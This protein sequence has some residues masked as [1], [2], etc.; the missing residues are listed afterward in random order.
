MSLYP[1]FCL[2][3]QSLWPSCI[4][5][6]SACEVHLERHL[7]E[8]VFH[9]HSG[10]LRQVHLISLLLEF[11]IVAGIPY[12]HQIQGDTVSSTDMGSARPACSPSHYT[13]SPDPFHPWLSPD[14]GPSL[15]PVSV[16]CPG[17]SVQSLPLS[18]YL[19]SL[20]RASC[21]SSYLPNC[22]V[23]GKCP[24][25]NLNSYFPTSLAVT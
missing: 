18:F 21:S 2:Y 19:E 14:K 12:P 10:F 15:P 4:P 17:R 20:E 25:T 11:L 7:L 24:R 3:T 16:S 8:V 23:H 1:S 22:P 5:P 13:C 9:S 6:D